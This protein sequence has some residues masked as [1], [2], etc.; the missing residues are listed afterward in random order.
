MAGPSI[1]VIR[2]ISR[3]SAASR[4]AFII[5]AIWSIGAAWASPAP[6]ARACASASTS[7]YTARKSASLPVKWWYTAPL[8]TRAASAISSTDVWA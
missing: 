1:S 4:Y 3:S 7:A 2:R 5:A 8:V 6:I